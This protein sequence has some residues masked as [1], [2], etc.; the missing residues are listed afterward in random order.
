MSYEKKPE[1]LKVR[2]N[3]G[4]VTEVAQLMS[5]LGLNTVCTSA[6]C[7]NMGACYRH[8]TATFM[9]L[10]SRCTRDCRFCDVPHA[11]A[12][13]L[14]PPAPDEPKKIAEAA[15]KLGLKHVVVTCVTRDD[16]DD[17]GARQ[18][19]EVIREVRKINIGTTVEVL[20]SDFKGDESALDTVMAERPDVLNHNIETVPS[21]YPAV[22]PQAVY[23]RSLDV[24]RRA[25]NYG[26]SFTKTGIMLGLGETDD[27]IM[28]TFEDV[29]AVG[30]DIIVISQYLQPSKEHCPLKRY[31]TPEEFDKYKEMALSSGIKYA[32]SAPLVRSSYLAADALDALKQ[33]ITKNDIH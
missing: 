22:R 17:G 1:W 26:T 14:C 9:I 32:V 8:R 10:G 12:G 29:S 2:Y 31:V 18:F 27:E 5:K 25:K 28:R 6:S 30:C 3:A 20:I 4:E 33:K 11:K 13:E 16:L 21:L 7:P 19:A 24:L 23:S 15:K